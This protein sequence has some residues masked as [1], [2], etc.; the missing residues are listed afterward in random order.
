MNDAL[1]DRARDDSAEPGVIQ[2]VSVAIVSQNKDPDGLGRVKLRFPWRENPDETFWARLAVPMAGKDRGTWFLPEVG[3]EV[4]VACEAGKVEHPYVLGSLW[5][6]QDTP[7][8]TNADGRND[9]RKIRS[10]SGHEIVFDDG[11][12]GRIEIHLKDDARTVRLDPDGIQIHDD[13]GNRIEITSAS[14]AISIKSA[15]TL[16][17]ESQ[18]IEIKAGASLTLRASGTLTIQGSLVQIN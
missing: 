17:I 7:P 11:A 10:R 13:S 18:S 3:D 2:G 5:N 12:Q 15:A 9:I 14:G 8:E 16:S 4:L 1:L 6:G